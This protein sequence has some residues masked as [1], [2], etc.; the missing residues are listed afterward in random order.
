MSD[1]EY[2]VLAPNLEEII[3]VWG[4]EMYVLEGVFKYSSELFT[5]GGVKVDKVRLGIA[6]LKPN[7][8]LGV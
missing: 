3:L 6:C 4:D 1:P 2:A 5:P 8:L 7:G